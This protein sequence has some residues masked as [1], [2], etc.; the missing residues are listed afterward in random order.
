MKNLTAVILNLFLALLIGCGEKEKSELSTKPWPKI[1]LK[2]YEPKALSPEE[3]KAKEKH[4]L[5]SEIFARE[6][7]RQELGNKFLDEGMDVYVMVSGK[8]KRTLK[9][10]YVLFN[11]V[12]V[13]QMMEGETFWDWCSRGFTKVIITD[14]NDYIKT[15]ELGKYSISDCKDML[16]YERA[17]SRK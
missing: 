12:S 8:E 5:D 3:I 9:L 13:H 4:D 1:D 15:L 17:E 14:G 7:Y 2:K 11:R 6:T 16:E 10:T